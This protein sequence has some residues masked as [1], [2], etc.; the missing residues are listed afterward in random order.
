MVHRP[1]EDDLAYVQAGMGAD[2]DAMLVFNLLRTNT[3]LSPFVDADLRRQNL[4]SAQF[5]VLL[6]LRKAGAEGLLM[7]EIGQQLV[8][9]KSNVTGLVDRLESQG[10]VGRAEHRDRR[11][12]VV[13]LTPAG[14]ELLD[15]AIPR[16][17][18]LLGDLTECL[19][20]KE[21]QTLI[22]LL[23]KLR[24]ELRLRQKENV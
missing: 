21:K 14:G 10:L 20:L 23:T 8:V 9:T 2:L 1:P 12:T 5:N 22:Q 16:H 7:G 19:T 11:A 3:C 17:A 24:R 18:E 15:R 13:R 6:V 4:T